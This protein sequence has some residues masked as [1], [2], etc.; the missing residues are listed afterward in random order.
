MRAV[1]SLTRLVGAEHSTIPEVLAA[2]AKASPDQVFLYWNRR[3]WT[4]AQGLAEI[5]RFSGFLDAHLRPP[6]RPRVVTYLSNRP[7]ALWGWLGSVWNGT[8]SVAINRN[9]KG[10]L[11]VDMLARS[12]ASILLTEPTA[13]AD[14]PDLKA[15]G[16]DTVVLTDGDSERISIAGVCTV[17][18]QRAM[19]TPA[20]EAHRSDPTA[21]ASVLYTSGTTGRSKAV[22]VPHNQYCRGAARLVD[23]YGCGPEDVFHNW[24]PLY[25]LGGQLHM[26]MGAVIA[27]GTV[28]LFPTF[29]RSQFF[30]QVAEVKATVICGFAAILH[31]LWSLPE[32]SGDADNTLCTGI[33]AGIPTELHERFEQ[34]FGFTVADQYGMTEA[35]PVTL[36]RPD[37]ATPPGS[38]GFP[39]D[40]FQVAIVDDRGFRLPPGCRGEI[41]LRPRVPGIMMIGYEDDPSAE[42]EAY[43]GLWFHTGDL[44]RMD[45]QGFLYFLG[46]LKSAIR[47]RGENISAVEVEA[48]LLKHPDVA[49]C[50]AVGVPSSL[51]E[52]EIKVVVAR[53]PGALLTEP[54]LHAFAAE[55]MAAFMV[56]RFIE[57]RDALPK[58]DLG[59]LKTDEVKN[60]DAATWD[61]QEP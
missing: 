38:C 17:P 13:V 37:V 47:R 45:E 3:Q 46:R 19:E 61:A 42:L 36:P 43:R 35:E 32:S 53:K 24:L 16:I 21:I 41:V 22:M 5:R 7:E 39:S 6:E 11:L 34:R 60:L 57:I 48:M 20:G 23:A 52:E 31:M 12:K 56:P 26:T 50:A 2:R 55:R 30:K 18:F 40:D 8:T 49:E 10:E 44:G 33:I 58:T 27:G 4:Y 29:S 51:G 1:E 14:L 54:D 59:K 28:A 9:H 25:H 15:L